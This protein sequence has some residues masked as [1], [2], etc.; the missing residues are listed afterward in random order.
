MKW[1]SVEDRLPEC[2]IDVWVALDRSKHVW[3]FDIG[4]LDGCQWVDAQ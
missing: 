4:C 3:W 2:D 1:I